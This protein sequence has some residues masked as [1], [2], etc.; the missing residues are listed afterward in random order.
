MR[1]GTIHCN[2][3]GKLNNF[4]HV[5]QVLSILEWYLF[6]SLKESK[7]Q[8]KNCLSLFLWTSLLSYSSALPRHQSSK[9]TDGYCIKGPVYMV[10]SEILQQQR[11]TEVASIQA[12]NPAR[13]H[14]SRW[15][16]L[17]YSTNTSSPKVTGNP[18]Y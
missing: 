4:M 3:D 8:L 2:A 14:G 13:P 5:G 9:S 12:K 10:S 17:F 7:K 15:K 1:Y 16:F 11:N 6:P 18:T